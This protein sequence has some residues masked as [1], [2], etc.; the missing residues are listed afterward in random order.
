MKNL[1]IL[2]KSFFL[3]RP[4]FLSTIFFIPILYG[5]GW[6]L[7]QPL[8]LFNVEEQN[9]SLIG[10]IITF[11][12]FIFLLPYWFYIKRNKSSA[13]VLL[14]ITKENFL[15]NFVNFSKGILFSLVLIILILVPLLQK[16]YISWIGE[17]SPIMLLNSIVLGLGVGFAEEIIFRGWLLEELKFEYG[18]KISIALQAI[19]FSFVHNLSNDI[20]W[21]II[22]LRIGFILLGIFLSLVKIR[23]KGSL[24][25]CVGL[26]GGLVGIWFFINNGLI[27]FKENTPSFLAGPFTQNIPNPI[28]SFS[29]I[30]I[31]LLLCIFYAV[32][33]KKN[34]RRRSN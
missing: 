6:A 26:H 10:T 22:G 14:G 19:V 5:I 17:F 4:R 33:S 1:M 28:G 3:L 8:L 2:I 32:K 31:L 24:W 23:D 7:S 15:K 13:W 20:F 30:L 34:F 25:N 12:L 29:A 16:N 9:L 11:F 21:N 18:T 27:E